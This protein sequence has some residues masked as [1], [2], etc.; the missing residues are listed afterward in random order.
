MIRRHEGRLKSASVI[1]DRRKP[2]GRAD[3]IAL[4]RSAPGRKSHSVTRLRHARERRRRGGRLVF[5]LALIFTFG[6]GY[7]LSGLAEEGIA[8]P[9]GPSTTAAELSKEETR[10]LPSK[11]ETR[12]LPSSAMTCDDMRVLVDRKHSLSPDYVPKHLVPLQDYGVPT[13]GSDVLRLRR[14]AAEHLGRLIDRAAAD[15][16]ELVVVSAYRTYEEQRTTH[17]RLMSIYGAGADG[18]SAAPGHS[19]HQLGT[20]VDF[21]NAAAGH[22]LG[23]HFAQTSA[24]R[25]LGHHA[26]EYGFVL[27]YPRGAKEQTGYQWE[28]WHYRY[29]GVEDAKRLEKKDLSLQE[30][31]E[32]EGT[33]SPC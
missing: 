21:T 26:R 5:M 28:P 7:S 20:A 8:V 31:L 3:V 2:E 25:W 23:V 1:R 6:V 29:V 18:M 24:Y 22:R 10:K 15:G 33:M 30:F 9:L 11:E 12:K 14:E 27:A 17:A 16:E 13:L 19:Q 4:A 32:R